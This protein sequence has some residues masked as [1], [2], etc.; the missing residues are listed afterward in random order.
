MKRITRILVILKVTSLLCVLTA[1]A[2]M[3]GCS[4][5]SHGNEMI[6]SPLVVA[7]QQTVMSDQE[8]TFATYSLP[9]AGFTMKYP[10]NWEV[11][12]VREAYKNFVVTFTSPDNRAFLQ[13]ESNPQHFPA[14]PKNSTQIEVLSQNP[15]KLTP[16]QFAGHYGF[17]FM[18]VL[19]NQNRVYYDKFLGFSQI[20]SGIPIVYYIEYK[21]ES[22]DDEQEKTLLT[23]VDSVN[24]TCPSGEYAIREETLTTYSH[25]ETGFTI[26]YP[27][28]WDIRQTTFRFNTK[29]TRVIFLSPDKRATFEILINTYR[30][31][32]RDPGDE[33]MRIGGS[34]S[35]PGDGIIPGVSGD[36]I[37][38][39]VPGDGIA[40]DKNP[41]LEQMGRIRNRGVREIIYIVKK[42]K[43]PD[44]RYYE[45]KGG[46]G[47]SCPLLH[48]NRTVVLI[49]YNYENG[50]EMRRRTLQT[51][52]FSANL[53]CPS[54][55]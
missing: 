32:Y 17:E 1:G 18:F 35:G 14:Y 24:V 4:T 7:P 34:G 48:N 39:G 23:M 37:I 26:K 55:N 11:K 25:P 53:T 22:G 46:F 40:F 47:Y 8:E 16:I 13:V 51:M 44:Q 28:N 15:K 5:T 36:G 38:P 33:A 20:C 49:D 3:A 27:Q 21:Y 50:D 52:L 54:L 42:Q 43:S 9:E 45:K 31:P 2:L 30:I 6:T 29:I 12:H 10:K 41:L 19:K